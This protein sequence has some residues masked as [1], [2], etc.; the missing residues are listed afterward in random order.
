MLD[1]TG[2]GVDEEVVD[3]GPVPVDGGLGDPGATAD[4]IDGETGYAFGD[5]QPER[6]IADPLLCATSHRADL[7]G[8]CGKDSYG[9]VSFQQCF[10]P[11]D[12][13]C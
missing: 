1:L 8:A 11:D 10:A 13:I 9:I 4:L 6:G 5:E 2:D 12:R 7:S 3:A